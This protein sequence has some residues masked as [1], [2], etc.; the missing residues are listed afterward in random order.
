MLP[1]RMMTFRG[2]KEPPLRG[3]NTIGGGLSMKK[4]NN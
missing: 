3:A 1:T 4:E 2:K